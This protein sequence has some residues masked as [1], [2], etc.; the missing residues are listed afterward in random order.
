MTNMSM[1]SNIAVGAAAVRATLT[2]AGGPVDLDASALLLTQAGKVR[3]DAD[4]VFYN[5]PQHAASAIRHVGKAP[6]ADTLEIRLS[7]IETVIDRIV[8]AASADGGTFG[9]VPQFA[10]RLSDADTGAELAVFAMTATSETAFI[11]GELYRRNGQWKFRAIG[12]GYSSGLAGL[13]TDFG[14]TVDD[15]PTP[16]AAPPTPVASAAPAAPTRPAAPPTPPAPPPAAAVPVNL[17]KGRVDLRKNQRV[18]LVKTGAPPLSSV[19]MG[20]GWD[21]APGRRNIDLDASVIAFDSQFQALEMVW[22]SH[23]KAFGGAIKHS[24]DNLTGQGAGDDEQIK[25][26]LGKLPSTVT[27]LMFTINSFLGQKFTE[28]ERA[29]CRLV[30]ERTNTELVRFDLSDSQ[31]NT[32]VLMVALSRTP[33]GVW[34]MQALGEFCDGKTVRAMVDPA[35]AALRRL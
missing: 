21:P 28:I 10:L 33:T 27:H 17:D 35:T 30:E 12:Q 15:Q 19:V 6:G 3:S 4:F 23:K 2:W 22:F 5:Q 32:G 26:N 29:F 16:V 9:Q 31:P 20:L 24:G 14:I 25:I 18:S 34:D 8:L 1:G 11:G 7:G 13:A